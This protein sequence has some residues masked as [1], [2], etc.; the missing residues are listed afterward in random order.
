M[1]TPSRNEIYEAVLRKMVNQSLEEQEDAF[2]LS[3]GS[4]SEDALLQ[5]L[6]SSAEELG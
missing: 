3:H 1:P 2:Q 5:Y 6:R 4:D